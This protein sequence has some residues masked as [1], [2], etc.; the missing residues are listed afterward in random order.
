MDPAKAC[1]RC[2][3]HGQVDLYRCPQATI[4]A[5]V[6]SAISAYRWL[7]EHGVLPLSGGLYD[8]PAIFVQSVN[9]I[10][11]ERHEIDKLRR[12]GKPHA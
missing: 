10:D 1:R 9:I 2:K 4:D 7:K 6:W 3:G 5:E 12:E 8:Q 11:N